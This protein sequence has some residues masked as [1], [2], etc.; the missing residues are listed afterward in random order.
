ME[1]LFLTVLNMSLT[2]SFVI[3]GILLTRLLLKKAPKGISY[4]LWTVAGFRLVFPFSLESVFSLIPFQTAPIPQNIATQTVPRINSGIEFIDNTV[5]AVLPLPSVDI[6]PVRSGLL[7]AAFIW[8]SGVAILLLYSVISI[9]SLKRSLRGAVRL[10]GNLYEADHLKTPFV[11]GLFLPRIYIP[12]ELSQEERRYIV[13][14]ER[15]HIRRL[16][17]AVK[18]LAYAV[19]CIHWFNPLVW[20]AFLLMGADMEMSCDERVVRQLGGEI[21]SAYSLSLVRVAAGRK[22]I[23]GS[24]LAF[25]EGNMKARIKN[26]MHYKKSPKVL[27]AASITLVCLLSVGFAFN[28]ATRLNRYFPMPG[29]NLSD[30]QTDN[31]IQNIAQITGTERDKIMLPGGNSN[32]GLSVT[33]SFDWCQDNTI[34]IHLNKEW[35]N[36]NRLYGCQLR[37]MHYDSR[38]YV[39]DIWHRNTLT[40]STLYLYDYL[41]ALKY[42]PQEHIRELVNGKPDLYPINFLFD[43]TTEPDETLA[44]VYYNPSGVTGKEDWVIGF[45]IQPMYVYSEADYA[46]GFEGSYESGGEKPICV[47]YNRF[48]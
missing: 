2:G 46:N 20:M 27:I 38:F 5:S 13:M 11:M 32:F 25:G 17:Y 18:I 28:K 37:I 36:S 45:Y 48:G 7:V 40:P 15:M 26:V 44:C 35:S 33:G 3:A 4:A 31:I 6:N 47:L 19:L 16:D 30:L 24:P 22:I 42:L 23:N 8:L 10:T 1:Q 41:N 34:A 39:T 9:V 12:A 29:M 43:H 21:K 14:H